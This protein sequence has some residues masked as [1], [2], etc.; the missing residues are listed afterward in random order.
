V[1]TLHVACAAEASYAAHS[2][3]ML[4][5]VMSHAGPADVHVHYLH[6]PGFPADSAAR[7]EAM[8]NELGGRSTFH[9]I[10]PERVAGLPVVEM[11]TAA[12]WFRIFLPELLPEADRAL[13]LDVD[14]LAVGP[15]APLLSLDLDDAYVAAVTNVFLPQHLERLATLSLR[16]PGAYFN[17]GVLLMNLETMR[18]D[19]CTDKLREY[20]A[21]RGSELEWPDQDALNAVLGTRWLRL[22]PEWNY[23]NSM[24]TPFALYAF[25]GEDLAAAERKPRIRHFEGPRHNKPWHW[26]APDA[27]RDAYLRHLRATPWAGERQRLGA[28][29]LRGAVAVK[30]RLVGPRH[31]P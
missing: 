5:S 28:R 26:A 29:M 2:A 15:L 27:D 22:G 14:T 12:M 25:G 11:F 8:L 20:A 30:R 9:E 31:T 19:G 18:R 13:Y 10:A 3:A 23:M 21:R 16:E 6:A 7:I 24:H 4:H 17:S 1:A